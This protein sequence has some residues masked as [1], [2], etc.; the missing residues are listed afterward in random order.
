MSF[1]EIKEKHKEL[2][3]IAKKHMIQIQACDH[4][5]CHVEDVVSYTEELLNYI[6]GFKLYNVEGLRSLKIDTDIL[7]NR[8]REQ[9]L[10][11]DKKE[12]PDKQSLCM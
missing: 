4:N 1:E 8:K 5:S 10:S 6:E 3:E 12:V 9:N 2:I 11:G 7:I